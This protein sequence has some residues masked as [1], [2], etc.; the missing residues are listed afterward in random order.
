MIGRGDF[1]EIGDNGNAAYTTAHSNIL[2]WRNPL[3]IRLARKRLSK[4]HLDSV[5]AR[6]NVEDWILN[7]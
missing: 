1:R 2:E 5:L 7:S 3:H 6:K 4:A